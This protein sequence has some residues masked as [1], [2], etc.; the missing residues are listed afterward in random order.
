MSLAR[1]PVEVGATGYWEREHGFRRADHPVVQFFAAQRWRHLARRLPLPEIR[2]ALDLGC[3]SGFS[4]LGTAEYFAP[5][6]CDASPFM[7][8]RHPGRHLVRARADR[9]PFASA[10]FDLVYAWELLHHVDD[11]VVVLREC[12]RVT[13]RYVVIFEPNPLNPAQCAFAVADAEHRRVLRLTRAF[14]E[15]AV[16][17]A[18]LRVLRFER[19]GCIFPNRTPRLLLPLLRRVPF[20]LPVLGISSLLI[21]G[22]APQPAALPRHA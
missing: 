19:V 17:A 16:R 22:P 20:S 6:G 7:L 15:E 13:R 2:R 21:A 11:V 14:L 3:G 8:R 1:G 12:A 10:S 4:S 5:V 9:L 18:G